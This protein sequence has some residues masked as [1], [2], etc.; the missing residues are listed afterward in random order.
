MTTIFKALGDNLFLVELE[1]LWDKSQ[2]LEGQPSVFEGS[3]FFMEDFNG[4]IP[5]AQMAFEK[6]SFWVRMFNIPLACMTI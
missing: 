3:F 5:P 2:V 6:A 4:S 1:H